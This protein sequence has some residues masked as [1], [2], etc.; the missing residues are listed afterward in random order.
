[1]ASTPG[2]FIGFLAPVGLRSNGFFV[3]ALTPLGREST[4]SMNPVTFLVDGFNLYHSVRSA[5]KI[6]GVSTKWLDIRKLCSGYLHLVANAVGE[7]AQLANVYYFSAL[8][9]HIEAAD[10]DV[11]LRHRRFIRCLEDTGVI[12]ELGRFKRR[13]IK[14]PDPNCGKFFFK[15]EEKETDVAIAVRLLEVFIKNECETAVLLTGDTDLA[16]AVRTAVSLFPT[17]RILFA[18]PYLRKNRELSK[19]APGS[20]TIDKSQYAKYQFSDPYLLLDG[21]TVNKPSTW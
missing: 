7:K 4:S 20:F 5:G 15:H 17:K 13:Q 18:F 12:V 3:C 6:L 14:C 11:T 1:M 16:P 10:P 19:L 21:T 8:A 2:I 9:T